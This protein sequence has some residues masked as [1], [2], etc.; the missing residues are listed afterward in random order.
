M[1]QCIYRVKMLSLRIGVYNV[2]NGNSSADLKKVFKQGKLSIAYVP[3][4]YKSF[5]APRDAPARIKIIAVGL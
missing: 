4:M 1:E 2:T 5:L 3:A